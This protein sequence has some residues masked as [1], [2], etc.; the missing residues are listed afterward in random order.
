[1]LRKSCLYLLLLLLS[2]GEGYGQNEDK[3]LSANRRIDS[4]QS[5]YQT[6]THDTTKINIL[7]SWGDE[8]YI[9]KPDSA[10]ILWTKA[11]DITNKC[12]KRNS[13]FTE[14]EL[15]TLKKA[16]ADAFLNIGYFYGMKGNQ[17][18]Y[19]KYAINAANIHEDLLTEKA[20]KKWIENLKKKVFLR[21]KKKLKKGLATSYNHI[22][23]ISE[24]LGEIEKA[25]EY[26]FLSLGIR[27]E[28]KDKIGM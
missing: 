9:N 12:L 11:R 8:I 1:M 24:R 22:G 6:A 3:D 15:L 14:L 7:L 18:L 26:Y 2:F 28:I 4:L 20:Q 27:E 16:K 10:L 21:M 23:F 25:L 17:K 13:K 5:A 19:L